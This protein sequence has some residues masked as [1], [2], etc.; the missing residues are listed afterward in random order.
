MDHMS[1]YMHIEHQLGFSSSETIWAKQNFEKLAL[2][3]GILIDSYLADNGV[4]KANAFVGHIRDKNQKLRFCGVNAHHKNA[5][6]E[7]AIRTVSE[8]A[9]SLLLHASLHWKDVIKSSLWPFAVSYATYLRNNLPNEQG[10]AP[11]DLFTGVQSPRHKLHDIHVWGAPVYVLPPTLQQGKKLPRW[12]PRAR[13]GI[14]LGFSPD[15][16]SDVPLVL[17]LSTGSVSPQYH[18]V[19]DDEFSTVPSLNSDTEPPYFWNDIDLLDHIHGH[20]SL[21]VFQMVHLQNSKQDIVSEAIYNVKAL[22]TLKCMLQ[23]YNG[24]LYVCYLP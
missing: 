8:C 23:L 6:A 1:S 7:Q 15:H 22:T 5:S 18:V 14:F 19:F 11:I 4:F 24:Q 17:N 3:S 20:S 13:R 9:R 12:E 21:N 10:L 16:S 2:D